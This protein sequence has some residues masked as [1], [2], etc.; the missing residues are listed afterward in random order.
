VYVARAVTFAV[1]GRSIVDRIDLRLTPGRIVA[2]VGPNGAGK[3][4]LL[5]LLAGERKPTHGEILLDDRP[6]REWSARSLAQRRAV[7]PQSVEVVFPFLVS[8]VVALAISSD[9]TA[10]QVDTLVRR[11]LA[12]V[13]MESF[14]DRFYGTLSG[15]EKQRVQLARVLAQ[16][17]GGEGTYLL[18]DEP[19]ASLD[20]AHQLLILRLAREHADKGGSVLMI[21]HDLNLACMAADEIVALKDGCR[22]AA[23]TPSEIITGD[24]VAALYGV[25]AKIRGVPEGPFLLP[26][27]AELPL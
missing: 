22:I 20:L 19:T 8:E 3:S 23:G 21:L 24:L 7:L 15:G 16:M 5:K 4:T 14:T 18:L 11:S 1:R 26:Q 10:S 27:T 2:V 25:R 9:M 17:P 12:A 6:L 13:D